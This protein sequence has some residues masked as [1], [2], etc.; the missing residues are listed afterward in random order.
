MKYNELRK[1]LEAP[2]FS[3]QDLRLRNLKVFACQLSMWQKKGYL[4]KLRSGVYAFL[5]LMKGFYPEEAAGFIYSPSYISL[6]KALSIYGLIPEMVYGI[7]CVTTKANRVFTNKLGSFSFR[8]LKPGLFFGY[9]AAKGEKY[10][11]L[12]AEAEKA[13]LDFIYLN[14]DQI[15]NPE[16][17]K[18]FR[19]NF[20]AIRK[21]LAGVKLKEYLKRFKNKKMARIMGFIL[22]EGKH[23]KF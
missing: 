11:Y 19:L 14:L 5:D 10:S 17:L 15:K 2:I 23:V 8:H 20:A 3:Q 16:D 6:E 1:N 9:Q 21:N 12:L 18:E 7:T 22:G 4:I 13:L